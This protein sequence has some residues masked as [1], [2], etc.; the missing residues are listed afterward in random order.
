MAIA[1]VA[2]LRRLPHSRTE[3]KQRSNPPLHKARRGKISPAGVSDPGYNMGFGPGL[4]HE[5][6]INKQQDQ[7]ADDRHDYP[8]R[9]ER[10]AWRRPG[11]ESTDQAADDRAANSEQGGHDESEILGAGH[12]RARDQTDDETNDDVPDDVEH[13]FSVLGFTEGPRV[14]MRSVD[15]PHN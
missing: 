5:A 14:G 3:E 15:M 4:V 7:R 6:R 9:M 12:N 11:E 8:R 10:G 1:E 13:S 2:P